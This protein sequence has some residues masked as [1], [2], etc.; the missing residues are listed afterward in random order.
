MDRL[1]LLAH[2]E[3]LT[4]H[5]S[6]SYPEDLLRM[7]SAGYRLTFFVVHLLYDF[8]IIRSARSEYLNSISD[9]EF[10]PLFYCG[11]TGL[12]IVFSDETDE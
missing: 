3:I 7:R 4:G 8:L 12:L 1:F 5:S 10:V 2:D 9:G 11:Q 6:E